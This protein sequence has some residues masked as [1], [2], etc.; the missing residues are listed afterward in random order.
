MRDDISSFL[1]SSFMI[2]RRYSNSFIPES[3]VSSFKPTGLT[4]AAGR[5]YTGVSRWERNSSRRASSPPRADGSFHASLLRAAVWNLR[6]EFNFDRE[7]AA[8]LRGATN[9]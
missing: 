4:L 9:L 6:I 1:R 7:P 3:P 2:I 8:A 5:R